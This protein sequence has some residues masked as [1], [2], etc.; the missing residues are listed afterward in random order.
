[1]R[2]LHER[3]SRRDCHSQARRLRALARVLRAGDAQAAKL[4]VELA[5]RA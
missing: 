5:T 3:T 4:L 1:M 2:R